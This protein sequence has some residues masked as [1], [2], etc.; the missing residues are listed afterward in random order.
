MS[1]DVRKQTNK[2]FFTFFNQEKEIVGVD[3]DVAILENKKIRNRVNRQ[4]YKNRWTDR[5]T[6]CKD[7]EK[8][9]ILRSFWGLSLSLS[10]SFR[11]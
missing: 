9:F 10:L 11:A 4:Q 5:R 3:H 2:V 6:K 1:A 8:A 7:L